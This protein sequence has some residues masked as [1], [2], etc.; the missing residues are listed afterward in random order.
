MENIKWVGHKP[1][2]GRYGTH[3]YIR[4]IVVEAAIKKGVGLE[5]TIPAGTAVV[6]P[7]AWKDRGDIR[8]DVF[9]RPNEPMLLYGGFVPIPGSERKTG[10]KVTTTIVTTVVTEEVQTQLL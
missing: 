7:V 4:D 5:I 9:L 8:K 6:D 10:K 1:I 2:D 3:V